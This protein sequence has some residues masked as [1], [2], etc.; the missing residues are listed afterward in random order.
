MSTL[1]SERAVEGND[2]GNAA[3]CPSGQVG[4]A[5]AVPS[6]VYKGQES[7]F[8]SLK[9][10]S[11]WDRQQRRIFSRLQSWS[12]MK[13]MEGYQLIRTDFTTGRDGSDTLLAKHYAEIK[14]RVLREFGYD[15]EHFTVRTR[16]GNGVLHCV[17]AIK[18]DRAVHI[19]QAWLST[20]WD[21]IHGAHR[22][23]IK[24]VSTKFH[25][26]MSVRYLVNQYLAGQ[27]SIVRCSYSWNKCKIALGKGWSSLKRQITERRPILYREKR[28]GRDFAVRDWL[29]MADIV[30]AWMAL[31][32]VGWCLCDGIVYVIEE[33][34]IQP[35]YATSAVYADECPF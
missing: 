27:T 4:V 32:E 28:Y 2:R 20:Q 18:Q 11:Q 26:K 33:N 12:F 23:W 35:K 6:L 25:L 24:R 13:L 31:I 21:N 34:K 22:V 17:W 30:R 29:P 5:P 15:I 14:R 9:H 16:E 1:T 10:K 7:T 19:P 8:Q 3:P